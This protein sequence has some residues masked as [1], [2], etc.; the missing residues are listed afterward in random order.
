MHFSDGRLVQWN[1]E[2]SQEE[3]SLLPAAAAAAAAASLS[4]VFTVGTAVEDHSAG[5]Q[6]ERVH[7]VQLGLRRRLLPLRYRRAER[8][9]VSEAV[10]P[11]AGPMRCDRSQA[12]R[13]LE[14]PGLC[15][16]GC[17]KDRLTTRARSRSMWWIVASRS[18]DSCSRRITAHSSDSPALAA[19]RSSPRTPTATTW[20]CAVQAA[21]RVWQPISPARPGT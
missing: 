18:S 2:L 13:Q 17:T 16:R 15:R 1:V 21:V 9:A 3:V 8:D 14:R 6:S 10:G 7:A 12:R 11:R 20:R 4:S 5:L 19:S